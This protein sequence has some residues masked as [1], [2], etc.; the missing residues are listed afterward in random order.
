MIDSTLVAAAAAAV[1]A[2][3]AACPI[4]GLIAVALASSPING[5]ALK[6]PRTW[7]SGQGCVVW[8]RGCGFES[9]TLGADLGFY[10]H[11]LGA[12]PGASWHP[13]PP[14]HNPGFSPIAGGVF[15]WIRVMRAVCGRSYSSQWAPPV[16]C[17]R[18]VLSSAS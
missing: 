8:N 18:W 11:W 15:H 17:L 14:F 2:A 1:D 10:L 13:L 3:S 5:L 7:L 6:A 9:H 12:P 16:A 4:L